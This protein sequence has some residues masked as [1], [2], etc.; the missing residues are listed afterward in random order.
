[1]MRPSSDSLQKQPSPNCAAYRKTFMTR[2]HSSGTS[3]TPIVRDNSPSQF[4]TTNPIKS[5][6]LYGSYPLVAEERRWSIAATEPR[7]PS[8]LFVSAI[9]ALCV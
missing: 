2:R 1:M 8:T 4:S 3:D 9:H 7:R 5:L 6:A